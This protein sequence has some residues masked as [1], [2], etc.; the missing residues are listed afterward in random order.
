MYLP[1]PSNDRL[2]GAGKVGS[3]E[4]YRCAKRGG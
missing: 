4:E 3:D 2:C 1:D